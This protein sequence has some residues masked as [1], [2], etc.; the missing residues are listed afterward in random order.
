LQA[1]GKFIACLKMREKQIA[2]MA[3]PFTMA[4]AHG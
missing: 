1:K 4:A 2:M 3:Q